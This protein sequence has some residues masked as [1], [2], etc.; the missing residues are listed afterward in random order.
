VPDPLQSLL[1]IADLEV[2]GDVPLARFTT[3]K[4]GGPARMM[5]K[6]HSESALK[7]ALGVLGESRYPLLVLGH[8]S[9]LLVSDRGFDGAVLKLVGGL[10]GLSVDGGSI[11]AGSGAPLGSVVG[12]ALGASLSG[13]EFAWGIPG[14]VGGAVMMNA[15]AFGGT[16]AAVLDRVE[17]LDRTGRAQSY[18]S[19]EDVYRAAL[20]GEEEIVT[21]ATFRLSSALE[22]DIRKRMDEV[23]ER[24]K[25]TQ[26]W[27][28]S[29]AGSVFKNPRGAFAGRLLE[30]CGLK[31]A[32]VGGA[33]VSEL[34]ANF[35]VNEGEASA[36][37]IKALIELAAREVKERFG[38]ELETEVRLVGFQEG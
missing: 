26:P 16:T 6:A 5:V 3:W 21:C 32:Q 24:R 1:R 17:T 7:E 13:L 23:G 11:T 30:E 19:F 10:A 37:D 35:I 27:G 4:V 20:V 2:A 12:A 36:A 31:G 22:G 18:D 8:G 9:N 25:G 28:Q 15:G 29:T 14:T 38:V 33:R 34:H